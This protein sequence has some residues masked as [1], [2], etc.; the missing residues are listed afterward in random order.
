MRGDESSAARNA[1]QPNRPVCFANATVAIQ[2]LLIE[3]VRDHPRA[4]FHQ[5]ALGERRGAGPEAPQGQLPPL[6]DLRRDDRFRI[7]D[8]IVGLQQ[9]HHR[10]QR[11]RQ[12]RHAARLIGRRQLRLKRLVEQLGADLA[13]EHIELANAVQLVRH[14]LL[15]GTQLRRDLPAN[16]C[17]H[18]P[19][20]SQ[21]DRRVDPP[22]VAQPQLRDQL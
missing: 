12:R 14:L 4:E 3:I 15:G 2:Q 1:C 19:I 22:A 9:R 8:L 11:R 16:R 6:V 13:Q 10:Q 18:A 17:G 5:R 21:A 20:R 7:A